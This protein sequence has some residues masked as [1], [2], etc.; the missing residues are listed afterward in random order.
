M[1]HFYPMQIYHDKWKKNYLW[2]YKSKLQKGENYKL[3]IGLR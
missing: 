1:K 3:W 2:S